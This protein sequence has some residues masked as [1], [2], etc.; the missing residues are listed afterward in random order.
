L[1]RSAR[2]PAAGRRPP[3]PAA[4]AGL[5]DQAGLALGGPWPIVVLPRPRLL[6]GDL[7]LDV[8]AL[9]E[10]DHRDDHES[11]LD[12]DQRFRGSPPI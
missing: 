7:E 5:P 4:P 1:A 9:G 2:S 3:D 12:G 6:G 11:R 8:P 10:A